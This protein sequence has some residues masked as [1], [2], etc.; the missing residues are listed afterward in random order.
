MVILNVCC[1]EELQL[2]KPSV[3]MTIVFFCVYVCVG[4]CGVFYG[5]TAGLTQCVVCILTVNV[6]KPTHTM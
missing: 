4:V 3:S 1:I 6:V 5:V 2:C